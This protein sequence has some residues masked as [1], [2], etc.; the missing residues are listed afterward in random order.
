M[1]ELKNEI[2]NT[3]NNICDESLLRLIAK[4]VG[5]FVKKYDAKTSDTSEEH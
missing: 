5:S 2:I 4:L 1:E 3:V